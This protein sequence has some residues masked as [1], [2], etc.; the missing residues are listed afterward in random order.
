MP[1]ERTM[2]ETVADMPVLLAILILVGL[3][4]AL[5]WLFKKR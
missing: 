1:Y 4:L 3:G 2:H 5:V